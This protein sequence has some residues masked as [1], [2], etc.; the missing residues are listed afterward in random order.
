MLRKSHVITILILLFATAAVAAPELI[1]TETEFNY[2]RVPQQSVITHGFWLKSVGDETVRIKEVFPGCGCT[3]IPLTDSTLAPGDSLKLEIILNTQRFF[4]FV[5]KKPYIEINNEQ[6]NLVHFH[7][8]AEVITNPAI[9]S[10]LVL[11]PSQLDVSQFTVKPRRRATFDITNKTSQT[12][13]VVAI[14]TTAPGFTVELPAEV[15]P[16]ATAQGKILVN[17]DAITD[18]FQKSFTFEATSS[19][20]RV[21]YT[22][23]VLRIYRPKDIGGE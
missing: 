20:Q 8:Y 2:G 5:T 21:R 14:D 13:K 19:E 3:K 9:D 15:G 10:P 17:E 11:T 7:I 12:F 22:I 18:S 16:N 4:G 23:P 6:Q 1:V